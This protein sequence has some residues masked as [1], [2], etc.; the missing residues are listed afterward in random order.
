[1]VWYFAIDS[2]KAASDFFPAKRVIRDG[3]DFQARM[4]HS[5]LFR[6][7]QGILGRPSIAYISAKNYVASV[8]LRIEFE[9]PLEIR[10]CFVQGTRL[11]FEGPHF[12]D[13]LYCKMGSSRVRSLGK[14]EED[15][16]GNRS[17]SSVLRRLFAHDWP[18][19]GQFSS[20]NQG[21]GIPDL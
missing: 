3:L 13:C 21:R 6:F 17:R 8:L 20:L 2:C 7:S 12:L 4:T 16:S 11:I 10:Q 19:R 9:A 1:M 15:I 14:V 18:T 5:F